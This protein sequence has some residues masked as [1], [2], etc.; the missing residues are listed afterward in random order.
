MKI[1]GRKLV[2]CEMK[3]VLKIAR[4]KILN[5]RISCQIKKE[6]DKERHEQCL[7]GKDQKP[8]VVKASLMMIL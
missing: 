6:R 3:E 1:K 8:S 7:N 2:K 5:N 4:K